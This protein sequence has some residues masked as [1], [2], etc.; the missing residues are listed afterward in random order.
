LLRGKAAG[1]GG[2]GRAGGVNEMLG[3]MRRC[4]PGR[5]RRGS[6]RRKLFEQVLDVRRN[7]RRGN[8]GWRNG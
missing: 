3:G 7:T 5:G 2:K 8:R 1:A 6:D 4:W